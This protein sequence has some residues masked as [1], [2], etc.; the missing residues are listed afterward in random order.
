MDEPAL[1]PALNHLISHIIGIDP[2]RHLRAD[3]AL[4]EDAVRFMCLESDNQLDNFRFTDY[5]GVKK[6]L[7]MLAMFHLFGAAMMQP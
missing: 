7:S 1:W 2:W 6:G 3:G 5:P 4:I